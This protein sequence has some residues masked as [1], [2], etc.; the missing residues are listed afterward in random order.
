MWASAERRLL[1]LEEAGTGSMQTPRDTATLGTGTRNVPLCLGRGGLGPGKGR[2][3][4]LLLAGQGDA[5]Q[6]QLKKHHSGH[7]CL[8]GILNGNQKKRGRGEKN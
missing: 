2:C 7:I 3:G 4:K 5:L 1:V 6:H 8:Y